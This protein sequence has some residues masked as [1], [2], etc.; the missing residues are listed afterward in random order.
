MFTNDMNMANRQLG[1]FYTKTIGNS[2]KFFEDDQPSLSLTPSA[3][4]STRTWTFSAWVK[5]IEGADDH[6]IFSA[7]PSTTDRIYCYFAASSEVLFLNGQS[8]STVY[9]IKTNEAFPDTRG[10]Y[11]IVIKFDTTQANASDR[12]IIYVNGVE[13]SIDAGNV[14][15]SAGG[16]FLQNSDW[17]VGA[18]DKHQISGASYTADFWHHGYLAEVHYTDGTAYSATS[19]GTFKQD[20]WIPITPSVTY[21]TNGFHFDFS[22]SA[23]LGEDQ[24]GNGN[25]Y[26]VTNMASTDQVGDTPTA[27]YAV[28]NYRD[29]SGSRIA[30]DEA[31]TKF[32]ALVGTSGDACVRS[33]LLMPVNTG[34]WYAEFR[35]DGTESVIG[36]CGWSSDPNVTYPGIN[37]DQWGY[38]STNGNKTNNSTSVAYGATFTTNDVIGVSVDTDT[39]D[40]VFYK[41]GVSQGTAFSGTAP[42]AGWYFMVGNNFI[43]NDISCDFGQ[44][45]FW[46]GLP[47]VDHKALMQQN[48][49]DTLDMT[50]GASPA[51]Y[52]ETV[53]YTGDGSADQDITGLNFTPDVVWIKN[54]DA[55]DAHVIT[56]RVRGAGTVFAWSQDLTTA[57]D[58]DTVLTFDSGGFSVGADV[59]VNTNTEKYA[60]WCFKLD[61]TTGSS[62]APGD[63][64]TTLKSAISVAGS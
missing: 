59:K 55:A 38:Y 40:I 31:G 48:Y 32:R 29:L 62:N 15:A 46:N 9:G 37:A 56:D 2:A 3:G 50:T 43:G 5:R 44:F 27:N 22:N 7:G 28:L 52:M 24:S 11:H 10:W 33:N 20:V 4:D 42:Y 54:R 13:Y 41:N 6:M 17:N 45:G 51:D 61:G 19:F 35:L 36:V 34:K 39:G 16:Q 30:I 25:N 53:L 26:T 8:G 21:G 64:T 14:T 12:C 47:D 60:A 49:P 23:N 1:T 18:T 63:I 58:A 57:S